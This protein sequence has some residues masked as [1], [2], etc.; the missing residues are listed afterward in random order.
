MKNLKIALSTA[1]AVVVGWAFTASA[2]GGTPAYEFLAY[3][4][5][6][7]TSSPVIDT[8]VVPTETMEFRFKYAMLSTST[9]SNF[10]TSYKDEDTESTRI[11]TSSGSSVNVLAYFLSK[12]GAGGTGMN[13][14][15]KA[16]TD[17]REGYINISKAKVNAVEVKLN[18]A[19]TTTKCENPVKLFG[20]NT[21]CWYFSAL[22]NGVYTHHY[23]PCRRT[24]DGVVGL[25]DAVAKSFVEPTGGALTASAAVLLG[26]RIGANDVCQFGVVAT[27]KGKGTVKADDG[28][29]GATASV[30]TDLLTADATAISTLATTL[31]ATPD[32]GW[33][34]S[35]W[36]G[37]V[38]SLTDAERVS[39]TLSLSVNAPLVLKA[40]FAPNVPANAYVKDGLVLHWD[41]I[42]NAGAE[43]HD[44]AATK[45]IDLS[46]NGHDLDLPATGIAFGE[47]SATVSKTTATVGGCDF[48]TNAPPLTLEASARVVSTAST[49]SFTVISVR[50]RAVLGIDRRS[51]GT[52]GSKEGC[53]CVAMPSSSN[54]GS[55]LMQY[56]WF[57]DQSWKTRINVR[58]SLS[59]RCGVETGGNTGYPAGASGPFCEDGV[60]LPSYGNGWNSGSKSAAPNKEVIIGNVDSVVEANGYRI[61]DRALTAEEISYNAAID[62]T[63]FAGDPLPDGFGFDAAAKKVTMRISATCRA[64]RGSVAFA[65]GTATETNLA[66]GASATLVATPADGYRFV[67]WVGDVGDADE[68]A[69]TSPSFTATAGYA[70][71]TLTALFADG[72]GLDSSDYVQDGLIA[73]WDGNEN[74]GV[75]VRN[76]DATTWT[77][78]KGG[79]ATTVTGALSFTN[80]AAVF[81]GNTYMRG[82]CAAATTAISAGVFTVEY[83]VRPECYRQ[84]GALFSFGNAGSG[85]R[86]FTL[87]GD[88]NNNGFLAACQYK[89]SAWVAAQATTGFTLYND[90]RPILVTAIANGKEYYLYT[91]GVQVASNLGGSVAKPP[92][93]SF[94]IGHYNQ[95]TSPQGN[96]ACHAIRWY[97]RV[98]SVDEIKSNAAVDRLR[99]PSPD[100]GEP[101]I[102]SDRVATLDT[103]YT[104]T[105]QTRVVAE[106]RYADAATLQQRIFGFETDSA[107]YLTFSQYI[108]GSTCYSWAAKDGTGNW[109]A[110]S[111]TVTV[112]G[113]RVH[114]DLDL[115]NSQVILET[116]KGYGSVAIT[117]KITTTR[118]KTS[119]YPL[120]LFAA[121][122]GATVCSN[123]SRAKLY[124]LKI[125]EAGV[126]QRCYLPW[127]DGEKVGVRDALSGALL[128]F[129]SEGTLVYGR[130]LT[131]AA[132]MCFDPSELPEGFRWNAEKGCVERHFTLPAVAGHGLKV[133]GQVVESMD[134]WFPT[135][136]NITIE[137]TGEGRDD[138]NAVVEWE[139]L[140]ESAAFGDRRW[141]VTLQPTETTGLKATVR[142]L[143]FVDYL[144]S[145]TLEYVDT[146]LPFAANRK[147][148]CDW[149]N[150]CFRYTGEN[151][152]YGAG[153]AN[154]TD[155]SGGG[156][157]EGGYLRPYILNGSRATTPAY[158]YSTLAVG[159]R[160][161]D[162]VTVGA[163]AQVV[164][165]RMESDTTYT[166]TAVTTPA[167]YT[168]VANINLFRDSYS[169][170]AGTKRIYRATLVD[171]TTGETLFDLFPC[172]AD[173][174]GMFYDRISQRILR[175]QTAGRF[176][177][178]PTRHWRF[179]G[180][181]KVLAGFVV[182]AGDAAAGT[183]TVTLADG[184]AQT[185]AAV[186]NFIDETTLPVT[187]T[188]VATPND[189]AAFLRWGGAPHGKVSDV[190]AAEAT[191]TVD[192][193]MQV[194]AGFRRDGVNSAKA[195]AGSGLVA[196]WDG[197]EN[198]GAGEHDDAATDWVDATGHGYVFEGKAGALSTGAAAPTYSGQYWNFSGSANET[199]SFMMPD[200]NVL[201]GQ[202]TDMTVE[203]FAESD[204]PTANK[205]F[206]FVYGW[207]A[208]NSCAD[209][210]RTFGVYL[211]NNQKFLAHFS[212]GSFDTGITRYAQEYVDSDRLNASIATLRHD[213]L[214]T[215]RTAPGGREYY[216]TRVDASRPLARIDLGYSTYGWYK[217]N[218]PMRVY[219]VRVYDRAITSEESALNHAL[220]KMRYMGYAKEDAG[221][222]PNYDV[223]G[224]FNVSLRHD[225]AAGAGGS[226]SPAG[227]SWVAAGEALTV[228]ATADAGNR[229]VRWEGDVV[230]LADVTG[231]SL[232]L[233][234]DRPRRVTA[235]FAPTAPD[236]TSYVQDGLLLQ[237]DGIR[238]T[239]GGPNPGAGA[240]EDL[241]AGDG[242]T[243]DFILN[244]NAAFSGNSLS[245]AQGQ[246]E[247]AYFDG[248]VFDCGTVEVLMRPAKPLAD[249]GSWQVFNFGANRELIVYRQYGFLSFRNSGYHNAAAAPA[250]ERVGALRAAAVTYVDNVP[251]DYYLEGAPA[252]EIDPST[253]SFDCGS[254]SSKPSLA[255]RYNADERQ[256]AGEIYAI[257]VYSRR[258]T[259][260]E[261]ARNHA[262]DL[263]RFAETMSVSCL[264][265]GSTAV[266][267]NGAEP[268][269]SVRVPAAPGAEMRLVATV[270]EG[271]RSVAWTGLP[272][273]AV[274]SSDG[275]TATF[276]V[277]EGGI[278][279]ISLKATFLSPEH[280]V[281]GGASAIYDAIENAGKGVH[282]A[283]AAK[284]ANLVDPANAMEIRGTS[285]KW[286]YGAF[287]SSKGD[288]TPAT[289]TALLSEKEFFLSPVRGVTLEFAGRVETKH[290][291]SPLFCPMPYQGEYAMRHVAAGTVGTYWRSS[292]GGT[293]TVASGDFTWSSAMIGGT[294]GT[295][296]NYIHGQQCNTGN[297]T[298]TQFHHSRMFMMSRPL[299]NDTASYT[300]GRVYSARRYE[301]KLTAGEIAVNAAVDAARYGIRGA[302]GDWQLVKGEPRSFGTPSPA[303]GATPLRLADVGQARTYSVGELDDVTGGRGFEQDGTRAVYA[304][305]VLETPA[306]RTEGAE[307]SF[308]IAALPAGDVVVTWKWTVSHQVGF[309]DEGKDEAVTWNSDGAT[310]T[311]T[312]QAGEGRI[313]RWTGLPD[314]AVVSADTKTATFVARGPVACSV[315]TV[316]TVPQDA[317]DY[318]RYGLLA[319]YDA[320]EN[321][322]IGAF[323]SAT[324][325]WTDLAGKGGDI[326]V[327]NVQGGL[328]RDNAFYLAGAHAPSWGT[329]LSLTTPNKISADQWT[330]EL[331]M[332][333]PG[334][335][336]SYAWAKQGSSSS[337]YDYWRAFFEANGNGW[338]QAVNANYINTANSTYKFDQDIKVVSRYDG[339][340]HYLSTYTN[341][342]LWVAVSG[343][344]ASGQISSQL[345]F[346]QG[347]G[348]DARLYTARVYKRC[349][350]DVEV[351]YNTALDQVR[352]FDARGE[353]DLPEG[354]RFGDD[355]HVQV[356][357]SIAA[358]DGCEVSIDGES[359]S[360]DGI[361]GWF[362]QDADVTLRARVGDGMS[363]GRWAGLPGYAKV[364][365]DGTTVTFKAGEPLVTEAHGHEPTTVYWRGT[366]GDLASDAANWVNADGQPARP[367]NGDTVVLDQGAADMTWD[368]DNIALRDWSQAAG[369]SGT[370]TFKTGRADDVRTVGNLSA[371]GERREFIVLNDVTIE[372]GT[373]TH[374]AQPSISTSS[375]ASQEGTGIFRLI[376][377][378]GRNFNLATNSEFGVCGTIDLTAKG[379]QQS[380]SPGNASHGG[381]GTGYWGG[382]GNKVYGKVKRVRTIGSSSSSGAGGGNL[383][384]HVAGEAAISGHIRAN[385]GPDHTGNGSSRSG[386][387]VWITAGSIFGSGDIIVR[388]E[389]PGG[390]G[391][392]GG[393]ISVML[394]TPGATFDSFTGR[395]SA[396]DRS[397]RYNAGTIYTET[398]DQN[399]VG[400]LLIRGIG[401][402][403]DGN[404]WATSSGRS[405]HTLLLQTDDPEDLHFH[406]VTLTNGV[407][408]AIGTNTTVIVD[409]E[410]IGDSAKDRA[411]YT[412]LCMRGGTLKLTNQEIFS[413][414]YFRVYTDSPASKLV[415]GDGTGTFYVDGST[416]NYFDCDL[417]IEGNLHVLKG[418]RIQQAAP[419]SAQTVDSGFRCNLNVTG[420]VTIDEGG[421]INVTGE[422]TPNG[423]GFWGKFSEEFPNGGGFHGGNAPG[424]GG[425][426]TYGSIFSPTNIG[427]GGKTY[428][429]GGAIR[430]FANGT[431]VNDGSIWANGSGNNSNVGTGAGGSIWIRVAKLVGAGSIEAHGGDS[432]LTTDA[433]NPGAGGRI[434]LELTD[435][436]ATFADYEGTVTARGGAH[437]NKT[438]KCHVNYS[439]AGTVLYRTAADTAPDAGLLVVDNGANA[440][441]ATTCPTMISGAVTDHTVRNVKVANG[442]WLSVARGETLT[443]T[444]DLDNRSANISPIGEQA[445]ATTAGGT[446][447][448]A[449][450]ARESRVTGTNVFTSLSVTTPGKTVKFGTAADLSLASIAEKGQITV[451]G[452][453]E[454]DKVHLRSVEDGVLWPFQLQK[455]AS[456]AIK[457]ADVKDS[458]ARSGLLVVADDTNEDLR[459]NKNW[460]FLRIRPGDPIVWQG[461]ASDD[462]TD[463]Y[464]WDPTRAPVDTDVVTIRAGTAHAP[465]LPGSVA[466]NRLVVETGAT[467]DLA[468]YDLTVTNGLDVAGTLL[469]ADSKIT[470]AVATNQLVKLNG[471]KARE[472]AVLG[473]VTFED[474]FSADV[475]SAAVVDTP[476]D[477][478]FAA[479]AEYRF[480]SFLVSGI[481]D[482]APAIGLGSTVEGERW[483]VNVSAKGQVMGVTVSDSAATGITLAAEVPS[484]NGGN[485]DNW[486][487]GVKRN[488]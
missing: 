347:F 217:G 221:L 313:C 204:L 360:A 224:E 304:G 116:P 479:G 448:F 125:Y 397:S 429:G 333:T 117:N 430:V 167:N 48:A 41:A 203:V 405:S 20:Y 358:A 297:S 35:R 485:N 270:P 9:W 1:C 15:T 163:T 265:D 431:L 22:D 252:R 222:P 2:D 132:T 187:A 45:W 271:T 189:G 18:R 160:F 157:Y 425:A 351:G 12:A 476:F 208:T 40:V 328:W 285:H 99:F 307:E 466:L 151:K 316:A 162:T 237:L 287:V 301:R 357:V 452:G 225:V 79:L 139:G 57:L 303:V 218:L 446:I 67:R 260:A 248:A 170:N 349:L 481:L 118:T 202:N 394:T 194:S 169:A 359:W 244:G 296:H 232:T 122:N 474:V 214:Q 37:D 310:V 173:E 389:K 142:K 326:P 298:Y 231:A 363:V 179:T 21:R 418:G 324:N 246:R 371:D 230:G 5:R 400:D 390:G 247:A 411:Q 24:A 174:E 180:D 113:Q 467:L 238:N 223:D 144:A 229:F 435:P 343:T 240:W 242:T 329:G 155:I 209:A 75:G 426:E 59:V 337:S 319:Q 336:F 407:Q 383:E 50:N 85:T 458:D 375:P 437:T 373:W 7:T 188:V 450:A 120:A 434:S 19:S 77:E 424:D 406:N 468:G 379:F 291:N 38:E 104:P 259:A 455:G 317:S 404:W 161:R 210:T 186:T 428:Y 475:F 178:G 95:V 228:T 339:A 97:D 51:D 402:G 362:R 294:G 34:F 318:L 66:V 134:T 385:G 127:T 487:F 279:A 53:Y 60:L 419:L 386:G 376:A 8:G 341:G 215:F 72:G 234:G 128:P 414:I 111:P 74:A 330:I 484:D 255:G 76:P 235:V 39:P 102:L 321:A 177:P 305:Y 469:A 193:A 220:D 197:L 207:S 156:R 196:L 10:F 288:N 236:E 141:S 149:A 320:L 280:Y 143:R 200:G 233:P 478:A 166:S 387:G 277:P 253:L 471:T 168:S 447:A 473:G 382:A 461:L 140:P 370:V 184:E 267:V 302:L 308:E 348:T 442:A 73:Q 384:L 119:Q 11:I 91:N 480:A 453:G 445:D 133:D 388:A 114:F 432:T 334:L 354:F 443:V 123:P 103:G 172:V 269:Q 52:V 245:I 268:S 89:Q 315:R 421:S 323:D 312:S 211:N 93:T 332:R 462:W 367:C 56:Y 286:L 239:R 352:F 190:F 361:E 64:G 459:N 440:V 306:G 365:D 261:I 274:V 124:F 199:L 278:P 488:I 176:T 17:V 206:G 289:R 33:K 460:A 254:A 477:I 137:V 198:Q 26:Y 399:G 344:I 465:A 470:F 378:V 88:L 63:R 82:N 393:R 283:S 338:R 148:I 109:T 47:R 81:D 398:A 158:T 325:V 401:Q 451:T 391:A 275:K 292:S 58:R 108:N 219:A 182:R 314:D 90:N 6:P 350:T 381:Q 110:M 121:R 444:G 409:G 96:F 436:I 212:G 16:L 61:Y 92:D 439:G 146:G 250:A 201:L 340:K 145:H 152:G 28:A 226:V 192:R 416:G 4:D 42:E 413:N 83:Y 368:I 464:N 94:F 364:T 395:M 456:A 290:D 251:T 454:D 112:V 205:Y 372:G 396:H 49:T 44:A 284:W 403:G 415:M 472:V 377:H 25:W 346:L 272:E 65:G 295:Y 87:S 243:R 183:V 84:Y 423:Y 300:E 482:E 256:F 147:F 327:T 427:S 181:G 13:N 135:G 486:L 27:V 195:Y 241:A 129:I 433:G 126:L 258:L 309:T 263:A 23:L 36:E 115:P 374:L 46:G 216:T 14:V 69:L 457:Y 32:T 345:G 185:G 355:G 299:V 422:G 43:N 71:H 369:Y 412:F 293:R 107:S 136:T 62:A 159:D 3:A 150:D 276:V 164:M 171:T 30:W 55:H 86:Y 392:G 130:D 356:R 257:R 342:V 331:V 31:T 191:L 441:W 78:L 449:D 380:Q 420:D 70:P 281:Q 213:G 264:G 335:A 131:P 353:I 165:E 227:E 417:T 154:T 408:A 175:N 366:A 106:Y 54:W 438:D 322:G 262:I 101:Y 105:P 138:P 29:K 410:V 68:A 100:D 266:S 311:L 282:S 249:Y 98:L 463:P 483:S 80:N 273:D 153:N